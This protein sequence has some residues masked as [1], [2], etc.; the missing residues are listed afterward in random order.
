M[1]LTAPLP[2]DVE[3]EA[4]PSGGEDVRKGSWTAIVLLIVVLWLIPTIGVLVTSFRPEAAVETT[5]WWTAFKHLFDPAQGLSTTTARPSTPPASRTLPQQP[6]RDHPVGGHSHHDRGV[7][8]LC[9]LV[10]GVP[11][12]LRHVRGGRGPAGRA[13]ADGLDPDS[14]PVPPELQIG[15]VPI[16]P[17]LELNGTFRIWLAHTAFGLPL[18]VYLLRNFIGSLPSSIIESAN[19][20]RRPLHDLLAARRPLVGAGA[21]GLA[22]FQFSGVERPLGG[23]HLPGRH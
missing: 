7:R 19:G 20:R 21:R 15:G 12:A 5:G 18:A 2:T 14:A 10:D 8:R 11:R 22:I 6:G 9:V 16:F 17:D 4:P 1:T 3:G 13:A 23:A